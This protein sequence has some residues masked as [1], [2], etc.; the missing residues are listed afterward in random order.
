MPRVLEYYR[1]I[2]F[3]TSNRADTID[4]AFQS[5]IHLTLHYPDLDAAAKRSIWERLISRSQP[6]STVD[7]KSYSKLSELPLNGRQIRNTVKISLLLASKEKIP[8][9]I[10]HIWTVLRATGEV[11]VD[12]LEL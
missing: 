2:L 7:E 9:G 10:Q 1:G 12:D 4:T 5:R 6:H 8:L 11:G 3:L